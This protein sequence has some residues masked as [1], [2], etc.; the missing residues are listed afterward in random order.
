MSRRSPEQM[1]QHLEDALNWMRNKGDNDE[2][3]D[4]TGYFRTLDSLLP[5]K[6]R[7]SP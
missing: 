3:N 1:A 5:K 7:Q 6:R 2:A 4:P